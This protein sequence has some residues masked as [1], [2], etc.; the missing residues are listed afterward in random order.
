MSN[1]IDIYNGE[2][3]DFNIRFMHENF[4]KIQVLKSIQSKIENTDFKLDKRYI[5]SSPYLEKGLFFIV[6]DCG[7]FI[8]KDKTYL[9]IQSASDISYIP[10]LLSFNLDELPQIFSLDSI[11]DMIMTKIDNSR[12]INEYG[13]PG[14]LEKNKDGVFIYRDGKPNSTYNKLNLVKGQ[15]IP[16]V[17]SL[18]NLS[19]IAHDNFVELDEID[20]KGNFTVTNIQKYSISHCLKTLI[21]CISVNTPEMRTY[22]KGGKSKRVSF[23]EK[24]ASKYILK[25]WSWGTDKITYVYPK[26][27][28]NNKKAMHYTKPHLCKFYVKDLIKYKEYSPIEDDGKYSII[29]W[30]EGCWK[31]ESNIYF[32]GKQVGGY[33]RKAIGWLNRMAKEKDIEIQ[34]AENGKELR[35]EFR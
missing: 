27:Q 28:S 16:F 3:V 25:K 19:I 14:D 10:T 9:Y 7:Y 26:T 15:K 18:H 34:H 4:I 8:W 6:E 11:M 24:T 31:G 21:Y 33:S 12:D 30:R 29:K 17:K 20:E 1:S 5:L 2:L 23:N 22:I 32:M 35:V 13:I